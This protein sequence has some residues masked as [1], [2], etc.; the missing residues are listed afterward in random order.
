MFRFDRIETCSSRAVG[1]ESIVKEAWLA[2]RAIDLAG[3][4]FGPSFP[5]FKDKGFVPGPYPYYYFLAGL[6]RSQGCNRILEIGTHFGGSGLAML[7]GIGDPGKAKLVTVDTTDLNPALHGLAGFTKLTGDANGETVVRDVVDRFD[8]SPID[9]MFVDSSHNF[10]AT[11]SS[12]GVYAL[13]LRPRL[14]VLDDIAFNEGMRALWSQL[15]A[16]Y[17]AVNCSDIVP[18]IR[19]KECGFGLL[20]LR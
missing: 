2:G 11:A 17:E 10:M 4:Q 14:V 12:V 19:I 9:L 1:L 8:G 20:R 18:A 15:R 5:G 6:V 7:R 16:T 3:I 13:L